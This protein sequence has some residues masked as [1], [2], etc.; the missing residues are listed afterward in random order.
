MTNGIRLVVHV[1]TLDDDAPTVALEID[2]QTSLLD[3]SESPMRGVLISSQRQVR[4]EPCGSILLSLL[5]VK[6]YAYFYGTFVTV[7]LKYSFFVM[8]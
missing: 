3:G 8:L 1:V 7:E 2:I 5:H 6:I 4:A